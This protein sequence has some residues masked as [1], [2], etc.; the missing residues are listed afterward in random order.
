MSNNMG[1][2]ISCSIILLMRIN[3]KLRLPEN[4]T[5]SS[6]ICLKKATKKNGFW[7]YLIISHNY[8][9]KERHIYKEVHV[10]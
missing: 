5:M 2:V 6:M 7:I 9:R 8:S 1:E 3:Y 10:R 4:V